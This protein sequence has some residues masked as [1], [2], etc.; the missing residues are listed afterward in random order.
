MAAI[1]Y[2]AESW[3]DDDGVD[4]G[5]RIPIKVKVTVKGEEMTIDHCCT[6]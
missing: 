1:V 5:K 4:I 3:L 6:S 2:E